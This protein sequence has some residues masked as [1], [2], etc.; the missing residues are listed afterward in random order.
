MT[1]QEGRPETLTTVLVFDIH[2]FHPEKGM[3]NG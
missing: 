3:A 1:E 2:R